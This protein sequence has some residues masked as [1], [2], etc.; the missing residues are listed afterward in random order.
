MK[1][2]ELAVF[3]LWVLTLVRTLFNLALIP[4]LPADAPLDGPLVSAIIPA[5]N[6]ERALGQTV[7]AL[8]AQRYRNLEVIVV[9]DRSTDRTAEILADIAASDSRLRI[10][11]GEETP[12]GWLGKPWALHQ[13]SRAARGELLLFLDAD[14]HYGPDGV[15]GAVAELGSTRAD[16]ISLFPNLEMCG[17]W[18]NAAMPQLAMMGFTFIPTWLGNRWQTPRLAIGG[19]PGNLVTRT[20]YDLAGGHDALR[21]AVI[22]DIGLARL[23]RRRGFTT[24]LV[25]ADAHVSLRMY[26]GLGEVVN[27]F[28]KNTFFVIDR[29][30]LV[31]LVSCIAMPLVNILPYV[32]ASLGHPLSIATV[33]LI[34]AVR[35]IVF[36]ALRYRLDAA[37]FLHPVMTAVWGWIFLRSMWITGV[38]GQLHW[39]GRAYEA[40]GKRFG[41][42]R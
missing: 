16:L 29:S 26:H 34:S 13:G 18:E 14:V 27:G 41:A 32:L 3:L 17:F 12:A 40:A 28:T 2:L 5:R 35:V 39:R 24:R 36:R 30:W 7:R 38:R 8:L 10:I 42:D 11:S 33:V 6:E 4:R 37:V 19:G 31:A 9:D 23:L 1:L 20:A 22:D 15:A 21:D 25:R